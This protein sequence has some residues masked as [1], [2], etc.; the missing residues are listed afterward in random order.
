M[1]SGKITEYLNSFFKEQIIETFTSDIN[2]PL[3]VALINGRYQLNAGSVNYSFGPLHDAFRKYFVKDPPLVNKD[4]EVLILGLGAGSVARILRDELNIDTQIIGVEVDKEVIN[5]ARK[6]FSL[7]SV[8]DLQVILDDAFSYLEKIIESYDLII[9]DLYIDDL[10]PPKF[11]SAEFI[12]M[13][14]NHLK[15]NGKVVFN[16]LHQV[17]TDDVAI[18]V[19]KKYFDAAFEE[20][21]IVKV[22]VNKRCPNYFITG[23]NKRILM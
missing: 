20:T 6:H 12:Q 19:L 3:E 17:N 8:K 18:K 5:A 23:K 15:I 11:E 10:V 21:E 7:D 4:S 22:I 9:V 2:P 14:A 16:K 13:V 1:R